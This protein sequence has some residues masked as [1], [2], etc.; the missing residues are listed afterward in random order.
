VGE[1]VLQPGILFQNLSAIDLEDE[2]FLT[3]KQAVLGADAFLE[4]NDTFELGETGGVYFFTYIG[5]GLYYA[6]KVAI[7]GIIP[8]IPDLTRKFR[9]WQTAENN[10][11]LQ[12]S[13][14]GGVTW[15]TA[16]QDFGA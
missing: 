16:G 11:E 13:D 6:D 5:T 12:F 7:N 15:P 14:D 9:W 1:S 8:G 2:T 4:V 10:V 3:A